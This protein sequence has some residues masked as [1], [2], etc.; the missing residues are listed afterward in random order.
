MEE[1][2]A[3]LVD[4][5]NATASDVQIT[6]HEP[7]MLKKIHDL[8]IVVLLVT[9]M[10]AMGCSI[11]WK[12]VWGHVTKP[13][14]VL[15]GMLSQFVLLPFAAFM[16]IQ[17]FD[18]TPLHAAGLLILASSPGGVTS[19]V[20]TYFLEGD[21]SLSVTMTGFSTV[22]ALVMMPF[23]V[24]LYGRSLESD[25]IIIP[26]AKMSFS[27]CILTAPVVL[28]TIVHWK[29]PRFAAV[30]TQIGS[31]AGFAIIVVCQ[32]MEVFIF[33]DIFTDVPIKL[34]VAVTLLPCLG[35][36]LGY[37]AASIF[38][39]EQCSRRTIAIEAG[40]QNVGTALAIVSLSYPFSQL[41]QVWLFPFLYAFSM[42]AVCMVLA[43][44]YQAQKR[45]LS[46]K[47][48]QVTNEK[49][50]SVTYPQTQI[51]I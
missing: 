24:W 26:Y 31:I 5:L 51:T 22:V 39:L 35:L 46:G 34:Y 38:K 2:S 36:A 15:T 10:F 49:Q 8:L 43:I 48:F 3:S 12:Q 21:L 25:T 41:R 6:N 32:T 17:A 37:A 1:L 33:P 40:I 7:P 47:S 27:L 42:L 28:G 20:F 29:L 30:L 18:I 9:V 13:V 45:F 19:N 14:G 11:T 44:L 16:L 50:S 4:T 23:N